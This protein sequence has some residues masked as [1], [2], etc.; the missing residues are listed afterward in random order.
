MTTPPGRR[1]FLIMPFDAQFNWLRDDIIAAGRSLDVAIERADDIFAPGVLLDQ[2]LDA[3]DQAAVVVGI[4]TGRNANVFFEL[5]YAWRSHSPVLLAESTADLPF[6]VAHY[7][8]LIYGTPTPALDRKVLRS[9]R[10]RTIDA[11]MVARP[12]PRGSRLPNAP[13]VKPSIR[14]VADLQ[15]TGRNSHRLVISNTGTVDVHDVNIWIP[16]EAQSFNVHDDSLPLAVLRPGERVRLLAS[17]VM[18]GGPSV[19]DIGLS[20][21]T[22]DGASVTFPS[23]ISL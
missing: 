5:G 7:R 13:T 2:V 17:V 22:A 20:G 12:L 16:P 1:G 3:I 15:E 11:A 9:K 8:T 23:K 6:D 18:G 19:F 14:L 21:R 4:C 10:A